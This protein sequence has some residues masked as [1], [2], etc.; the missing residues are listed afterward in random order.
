VPRYVIVRI[1]SVAAGEMPAV[2]R[3]SKEIVEEQF[4]QI[5]WEHS[6]VAVD[7]AGTVRTFCVY[8]APNEETI[9]E[10]AAILGRHTI[11]SIH[12]LAGD[13]SPADFPS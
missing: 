8:E 10:H 6:H 3:C 9:R 11:D 5:T 4:P 7:D 12:E 1:F 13:V 2:G